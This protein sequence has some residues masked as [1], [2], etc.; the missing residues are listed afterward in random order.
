MSGLKYSIIRIG[1]ENGEIYS[2]YENI[3]NIREAELLAQ[4]ILSLNSA[5]RSIV[6]IV[7]QDAHISNNINLLQ[8]VE[9]LVKKY[10]NLK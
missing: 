8:E 3:D 5:S 7:P 4:Y 9:Q 10:T 2:L 6:A 1:I